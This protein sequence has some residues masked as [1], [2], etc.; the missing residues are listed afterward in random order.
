MGGGGRW[1]WWGGGASGRHP[2]ILSL[3][4]RSFKCEWDRN[5]QRG[6][7]LSQVASL[8]PK[9]FW[10]QLNL[11]FMDGRREGGREGGRGVQTASATTAKDYGQVTKYRVKDEE[12]RLVPRQ[13]DGGPTSNCET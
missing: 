10:S 12:E 4:L 11:T 3:C 6:P 2:L 7:A 5:E 9:P 13:L 1:W 8:T